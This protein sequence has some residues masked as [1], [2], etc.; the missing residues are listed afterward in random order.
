MPANNYSLVLHYILPLCVMY[1]TPHKLTCGFMYSLIVDTYI[2]MHYKLNDTIRQSAK[3]QNY[4]FPQ[5]NLEVV[6]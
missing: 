3:L 4:V 6:S 2:F 5:M 1:V